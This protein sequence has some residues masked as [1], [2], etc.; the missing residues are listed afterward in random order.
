M[1]GLFA[2]ISSWITSQLIY[3][4]FHKSHI[5]PMEKSIGLLMGFIEVTILSSRASSNSPIKFWL[6]KTLQS[7]VILKFKLLVGQNIC[8]NSKLMNVRR[9]NL[10]GLNR[11]QIDIR[12]FV[13]HRV[14]SNTFGS[15]LSDMQNN[16]NHSLRQGISRTILHIYT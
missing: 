6:L 13:L 1:Y 9:L 4:Y 11:G 2:Y 8:R 15:C 12:L 16:R 5:Y 14:P 3:I 7:K 10:S